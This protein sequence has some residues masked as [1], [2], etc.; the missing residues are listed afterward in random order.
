VTSL[1]V[2]EIF[3]GTPWSE[4][5]RDSYAAFLKQ[6]GFQFYLYG[7]KGDDG[8]RKNW[9]QLPSPEELRKYQEMQR[10]F[11]GHGLQ[12]GMILSPHSLND[13]FNLVDRNALKAKIKVLSD[14]GLDFLGLFFDDMKSATNL[15]SRQLEILKVVQ[16]ETRAKIIFCPSFYSND[17]LL[18]MLFGDRPTDYLT[19]LGKEI[20]S[21][22]E[23]LWTGEQIISPEITK[24][25]LEPV[26]KKLLRKPFVC[27]NFY[28]DDGPINCNFLRLLAPNG[29]DQAALTAASHWAFNPMNQAHLSKLVIRAAAQ[30]MSVGEKPEV[31]LEKTIR[32]CTEPKTAD[33]ILEHR[34]RFA[35]TGLEG[36]TESEREKLRT[37]L[38]GSVGPVEHEII[39]W[40]SGEYAIDFIKMLEQSCFVG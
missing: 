7:P 36:I 39:Q 16:E 10:H 37:L 40:L 32:A 34:A 24:A 17:S 22:V 27:D 26:E 13:E 5:D 28:A 33:F 38:A 25:D 3:Y 30:T 18:D 12:F 9:R 20:D 21:S 31:A 4:A 23:I 35:E 14:V 2:M 11:K 15:A 6:I 19:T 8:L 1:G 29:R